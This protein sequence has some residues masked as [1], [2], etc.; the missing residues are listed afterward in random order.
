MAEGA[1]SP[2]E[3]P[4]DGGILVGPAGERRRW[5]AALVVALLAQPRL[6]DLE[7]PD[8]VAAVGL[9]AVQAALFD[10]GMLPQE[11]TTLVRVAAVAVLVDAVLRDQ[12]LGDGP[13]N[14]MATGALELPLPH[15]HMG[16]IQLLGNAD[17]VTLL[18][19]TELVWGG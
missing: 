7:Q 6:T 15:G 17:R 11:R 16:P 19:E 10:R 3:S 5:V 9:V 14:V 8:V 18:A 4:V 12:L 1:A 2:Q 13:V